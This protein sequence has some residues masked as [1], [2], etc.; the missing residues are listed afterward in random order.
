MQLVIE[1]F[2]P[3]LKCNHMLIFQKMHLRSFLSLVW[4]QSLTLTATWFVLNHLDNFKFKNNKCTRYLLYIHK[5]MRLIP[6]LF[7]YTS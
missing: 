1:R 2:F 7:T 6:E 3:M 4:M 5:Y